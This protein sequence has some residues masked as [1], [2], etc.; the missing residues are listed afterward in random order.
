MSDPI[1]PDADSA[2]APP[3]EPSPKPEPHE[4]LVQETQ[5]EG[6]DDESNLQAAIEDAVA[7]GK[8]FAATEGKYQKKLAALAPKLL[9]VRREI[10]QRE[11]TYKKG[12]R[13]GAPNWG[14]FLKAWRAETGVELCDKT[15][16]KVLDEID[17]TKPA[18]QPKKPRAKTVTHD[19]V[20]K[21]TLAL[22]AVHEALGNVDEHG[23]VL[24]RPEDIA[25]I[26]ELAPTAAELNRLLESLPDEAEAGGAASAQ[27]SQAG[28]D[29]AGGAARPSTD[30]SSK[31]MPQPAL[32]SGDAAGLTDAVIDKCT[33]EFEAVLNDLPPRNYAEVISRVARGVAK[34]FNRPGVGGFAIKVTH[35]LPKRVVGAEPA[36]GEGGRRQS[37][38][39]TPAPS[40]AGA[41]E[42]PA[43]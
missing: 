40:S 39:Q 6:A 23:S 32:T 11:K 18:P 31:P 37:L 20:R 34:Q 10:H 26:L 13:N 38:F 29:Q 33:P 17:E 19:E 21:M 15:I 5:P 3:E 43:S 30:P 14:K 42:T 1:S 36:A 35:V 16:K 12:R 8:I 27:P 28:P 22:L 7:E 25:P 24:L 9:C 4:E 2:Q 41:L